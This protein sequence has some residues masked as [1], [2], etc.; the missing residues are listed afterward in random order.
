MFSAEK[1]AGRHTHSSGLRFRILR[2][3]LSIPREG[4]APRRKQAAFAPRS[5][6]WLLSITVACLPTPR[7]PG[8]DSVEN[9]V[10]RR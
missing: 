3:V 6:A 1:I 8:M 9:H 10:P 7:D 4:L 2:S 5:A